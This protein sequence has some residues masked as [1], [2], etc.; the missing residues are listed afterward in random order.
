[1]VVCGAGFATTAVMCGKIKEE[2]EK[3]GID[4]DIK[5]G[6]ISRIPY[7]LR[8]VDLIVSSARIEEDYGIPWVNGVPLITGIGI[9]K[10]L[11][12]IIKKLYLK[13]R[14]KKH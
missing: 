6:T 2:L 1:M 4:V 14:Q 13:T 8:G 7:L 3:R 5:D 12:E 10:T 9:N 11:K